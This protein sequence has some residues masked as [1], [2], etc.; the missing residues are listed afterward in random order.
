MDM[1][2][3]FFLRKEDC[4]AQWHVLDAQ[5]KALGRLATEIA[6]HLAG[7]NKTNFAPQTDNGDYVVVVNAKNL[8]LSGNKMENKVYTRVSGWIGG[9]KEITAKAMMAKDPTNLVHLAVRGMLPKNKLGAQML[10]RLK[11]YAEDQH[12]HA[13]QIAQKV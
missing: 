13:A 3:T 8:V 7:K 6:D 4:F 1:N 9:K 5:S 2:K 11:V 10:K 12:P